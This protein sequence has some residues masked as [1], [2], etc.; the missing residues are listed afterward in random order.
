MSQIITTP[1]DLGNV[2][3][4][5]IIGLMSSQSAEQVET[6]MNNLENLIP[7]AEAFNTV[8]QLEETLKITG[9]TGTAPEVLKAAIYNAK[10]EIKALSDT[11]KA[12]IAARRQETKDRK[13]VL[14]NQIK[15]LT[16]E[17][18]IAERREQDAAKAIR[19]AD[20]VQRRQAKTEAEAQK[21]AERQARRDAEAIIVAEKAE[22]R[23]AREEARAIKR[24]MALNSAAARTAAAKAREEAAAAAL[25]ALAQP[26]KKVRVPR[27]KK[28]EPTE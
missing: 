13:V 6:A 9:A 8:E 20:R 26:A 4:N 2:F 11:Q 21:A 25:A 5:Q 24:Q 10:K 16:I 28:V 12:D 18:K 1:Q 15:S 19:I 3:A 27:V 7:V 22:T 23:K 14:Q 17:L